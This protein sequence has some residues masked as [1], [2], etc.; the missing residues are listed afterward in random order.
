MAEARAL[1]ARWARPS[2]AQIGEFSALARDVSFGETVYYRVATWWISGQGSARNYDGKIVEV[3]D[4]EPR[5]NAP[6]KK[7]K[8]RT[9]SPAPGPTFECSQCGQLRQVGTSPCK[10]GHRGN[11]RAHGLKAGDR[12]T[13]AS[14]GRAFGGVFTLIGQGPQGLIARHSDGRVVVA[15]AYEYTRVKRNPELVAVTYA[16]KK[17]GDKRPEHYE[18]VFEGRRPNLAKDARGNLVIERNGS[19]YAVKRDHN[20]DEW[21]FD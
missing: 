7:P 17:K 5:Q 21:I 10:C 3:Y 16:D 11:P 6:R 2:K 14:K 20:G 8:R 13:L 4:S 1:V 19:R 18:H 9:V 15:P 12:V